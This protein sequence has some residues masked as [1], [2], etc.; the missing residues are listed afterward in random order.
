MS[1]CCNAHQ[2]D[3][4]VAVCAY[5][6]LILGTWRVDA[7]VKPFKLL[8]VFVHVA[9]CVEINCNALHAIDAM[10]VY[11]RTGGVSRLRLPRDGRSRRRRRGEHQR[12]RRDA[13][14]RRLAPLR[15]AGGLLGRRALGRNLYCGPRLPVGHVLRRGVARARVT[16]DAPEFA[17]DETQ[18]RPHDHGHAERILPWRLRV[19][20]LGEP[21]GHPPRPCRGP[22]RATFRDD[23]RLRLLGLRHLRRLR[24]TI[25]QRFPDEIRR[26]GLRAAV[27]DMSGTRLGRDMARHFSGLVGGRRLLSCVACWRP[28][29]ST[30]FA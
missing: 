30:C 15:D 12:G 26:G 20:R 11:L 27:S 9:R 14:P 3:V 18:R 4:I 16:S 17:V 23:L 25:R 24:A 13:L 1:L 2:I 6:V 8:A 29:R 22:V 21:R 5:T 28:P 10:L 19:S 7:V